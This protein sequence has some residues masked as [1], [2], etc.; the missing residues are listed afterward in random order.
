MTDQKVTEYSRLSPGRPDA[1]SA[2][3][4]GWIHY[5]AIC[6]AGLTLGLTWIGP[7]AAEGLGTLNAMAFWAS[8][9]GPALGL[10]ALTQ[11]SLSRL[12]TIASL[13]G[14]AQVLLTAMVASL[15]FTPVA[16]AVDLLFDAEPSRDDEGDPLVLVAVLEFAQFAVPIA[17][18]WTLINAP[19]LMRIETATSDLAP[20]DDAPVEVEA[21]SAQAEFWSRIPRRLGRDIIAMSAELHYLR[22]YT[23]LGNTL[24]LYP[25]GRATDA[26]VDMRGMQV[27]RSHWVA[28]DRVD[29]VT[30]QDGRTFCHVAGGP[31]LP[32]SR[33]HR[34]ALRAALAGSA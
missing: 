28:L 34:S 31:V 13:P 18:T 1:P 7:S 12:R 17:L 10:L 3:G 16:L 21:R 11:T 29:E 32:V 19:S 22:V 5:L 4:L 25:F 23:T 33:S 14:L 26:L 6:G 30:T 8:H 9:V 24:I 2:G 20:Q 15:L 27:H